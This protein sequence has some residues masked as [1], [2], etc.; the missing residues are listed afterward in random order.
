MSTITKCSSVKCP[1]R[2]SCYRSTALIL[3]KGELCKYNLVKE[4]IYNEATK[5]CDEFIPN[6]SS[7]NTD[8]V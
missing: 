8:C 4:Y 6:A 3:C 5:S 2:T 7:L 1:I